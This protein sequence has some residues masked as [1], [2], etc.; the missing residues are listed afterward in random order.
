M[1]SQK[2]VHKYKR[3]KLGKNGY[4]VYACMFP[5]CTHYLP[6]DRVVGRQ[7]ICWV[8]G[9]IMVVYRD[10]NGLLAKPHCRGCYVRKPRK[11]KE[12]DFPMPTI[13]TVLP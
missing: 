10:T 3:V 13:P 12:F 6:E 5:D 7:S 2:H 4:I 1:A 11:K 8:C 9:K